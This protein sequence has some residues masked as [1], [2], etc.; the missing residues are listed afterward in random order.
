LIIHHQKLLS[1]SE[2]KGRYLAKLIQVRPKVSPGLIVSIE[3][4]YEYLDTNHLTQGYVEITNNLSSF[5][6]IQRYL[7]NLSPTNN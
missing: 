7:N 6:N 4:F 1:I 2:G 5:Y 3:A